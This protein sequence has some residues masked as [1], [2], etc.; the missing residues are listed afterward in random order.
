MKL[1][2][3]KNSAI[4]QVSSY[5]RSEAFKNGTTKSFTAFSSAGSYSKLALKVMAHFA[6]F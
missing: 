1:T 3:P 2:L 5:R 4:E 6:D